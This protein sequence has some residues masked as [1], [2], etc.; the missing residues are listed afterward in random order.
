MTRDRIIQLVALVLMIAGIAGAGRA[1]PALLGASRDHALRYTDEPVEGAPPI[2]ALGTA[3]GA[4]RGVIVDYL[5]L[6]VNLMKEK[7]L[8]YEVMHDADLITRLQPRFAEVWAFHGHNMAY[9]I[10]V[11]MDSPPER[12]EWVKAGINLVRNKGLRYNPNDLQLHRE[13][14]FWF[15]HKLEGVSDDAHLHYKRE[16]RREWHD[17]L[18]EPPFDQQ[19]RAEWLKEIADAPDTLEAAEARTAGVTALVD[20]L[21]AGLSPYEK[22]FKFA[23][24]RAFLRTYGNWVAVR[25]DSEAARVLGLE[26]EFRR[27]SSAFRVFDEIAADPAAADAWRT[28]IAH[29]RKRVLVDEYNMDPR[30]MYEF[31]R[32]VGPFDWRHGESHA[33]YWSRMGT[34]RGEKR[35]IDEGD[36][37]KIVN[38]D[39]L[40]IQAMQALYKGGR[41]TYDPF[42]D[43]AN[44]IPSQFPESRWVDAIDKEFDRL[45][46]KHDPYRGMGGDLFLDFLENFMT[47]A[48]RDYYR[49]F[50][51]DKAQRI[52]DKLD[53]RFGRGGTPPSYR[54]AKPLDAFVRDETRGE[55]TYQ[56]ELARSDVGSSLRGGLLALGQGQPDRWQLALA[57]A[58][59]ITQHFKG[60]DYND[61]ITKFGEGRMAALLGQLDASVP[62]VI[63]QV[64]S[65]PSLKMSFRIALWQQL[66]EHGPQFKQLAWSDPLRRELERQ[67]AL[68]YLKD[69]YTVDQAFPAPVGWEQAQ[70]QFRL[71]QERKRAEFLRD[72]PA[73]ID[74]SGSGS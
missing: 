5:W 65:D 20:R 22:Q 57:F 53:A 33:Y 72:R 10:S 47:A 27:S 62:A 60:N 25:Q 31:T 46:V 41:I 1:L 7:G 59:E 50:E 70:T 2:V 48:I 36:Y 19:A 52:L 24:D 51:F 71:E 28:L 55:Y 45:A 44:T 8:V 68:S 61:Y 29:V 63:T 73:L 14:A 40:Q 35:V 21:K 9:N 18:G 30:M 34:I 66:D 16:F 12:W 3:I 38:N 6:K 17:I 49:G 69:R 67:L 11:T 74:Q 26:D 23:L 32:D 42:D 64:I 39:R 37:F 15:K 4:L 56:P 13:L 54:F 58:D 43:L